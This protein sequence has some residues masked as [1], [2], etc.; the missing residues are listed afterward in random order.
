[1]ARSHH[2]SLCPEVSYC[3]SAE[4]LTSGSLHCVE[5]CS[6]SSRVVGNRSLPA[7][8]TCPVVDGEHLQHWPAGHSAS[9]R[10]SVGGATMGEDDQYPWDWC[11]PAVT[12]S[13]EKEEE[14]EDNE[15]GQME[16]APLPGGR[17]AAGQGYNS[18]Y[19]PG[20][21]SRVQSSLA[22]EDCQGACTQN[23]W[24]KKYKCDIAGSDPSNFFC[25]PPTANIPRRQLSSRNKLWCI[26]NCERSRGNDYYE[27]K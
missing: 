7:V 12:E 3:E 25:S 26:G 4:W 16:P 27:C 14:E 15:M 21:Y 13:L 24:S 6:V 17:A 2:I 8:Y 5:R 18:G 11:T 1:M 23:D 22:G 20:T 19:N 10:P 9:G